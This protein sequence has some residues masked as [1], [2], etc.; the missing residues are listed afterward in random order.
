M[1]TKTK[2]KIIRK[3]TEPR[4]ESVGFFEWPDMD[5]CLQEGWEPLGPPSVKFGDHMESSH[6][7]QLLTKKEED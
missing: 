1:A 6:F 3:V 5:R 7:F 4:D 2:Y